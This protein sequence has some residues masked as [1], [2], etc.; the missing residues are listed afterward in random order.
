[1]NIFNCMFLFSVDNQTNG[2]G[3]IRRVCSLVDLSTSTPNKDCQPYSTFN[4][5]GK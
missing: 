4:G 3:T 2:T 1:M 5:A